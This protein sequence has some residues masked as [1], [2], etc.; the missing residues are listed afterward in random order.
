ML[1]FFALEKLGWAEAFLRL[2]FVGAAEIF[3][4]IFREN[5]VSA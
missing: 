1:A 2:L 4:A 5:F 3:L